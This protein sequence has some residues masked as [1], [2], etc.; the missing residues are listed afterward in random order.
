MKRSLFTISLSHALLAIAP[1]AAFAESPDT[2]DMTSMPMEHVSLVLPKGL[3]KG[4]PLIEEAMTMEEAVAMGLENN[5]GLKISQADS[6]ISETLLLKAKAKRWPVI[7][8]GSLTFLRGGNSQVLMTP[9]S[10]MMMTNDTF[11]ENFSASL[12]TPLYT[13]GRLNA[14]VKK[15]RFDMLSARSD[16]ELTAVEMAYQVRAA[17]LQALLYKAEHLVH[18]EHIGVQQEL[19]RIAQ[20]RYREGNGLKSD[21]LRVRT[22]LANAQRM[23]NDEHALLNNT[24]FDLKAT[25]GVDLASEITVTDSLA[26]SSWQG[27]PLSVLIQQTLKKHPAI[28]SAEAEIEAARQNLRMVQAQY[29]P[30]VYGQVVGN[31][32]IP[33][34]DQNNLNLRNGVIGMIESV[35]RKFNKPKPA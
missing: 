16:V 19:L 5:V 17:Y 22:E 1:L 32:R 24:L 21:V 31:L 7:R 11:F 4:F 27:E 8:V 23:L 3:L 15:A 25:M 12:A 33:Q 26:F 2:H 10:M 34:G 35:E 9:E 6:E 30:Q 13:G 14:G 28:Q 18:Q 20:A 29:L